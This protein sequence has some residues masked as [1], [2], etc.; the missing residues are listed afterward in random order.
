MRSLGDREKSEVGLGAPNLV[1][2]EGGG[3]SS[4]L[5]D[6]EG[7]EIDVETRKRRQD[8]EPRDREN[9]RMAV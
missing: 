5:V 9:V 8:R 2:V 6:K 4:M 3:C 7:G 1:E